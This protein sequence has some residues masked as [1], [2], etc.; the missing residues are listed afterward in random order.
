MIKHK[1]F[2]LGPIGA[3][4]IVENFKYVDFGHFAI[5]SGF[6]PLLQTFIA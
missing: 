1:P 5:F 6:L 2:L 4:K 3:P